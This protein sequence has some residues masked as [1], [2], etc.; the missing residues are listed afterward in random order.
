MP[1]SIIKLKDDCFVE[2]SSIC[3]APVTYC[4]T[5]EKFKEYLKEE[6]GN[7]RLALLLERLE[8]IDLGQ[9]CGQYDDLAGVLSY[10]RA[11]DNEK[12]IGLEKI[13]EKYTEKK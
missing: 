13:I 7:S 11:G 8:K 2:W 10:N 1:R 4:M 6:Y 5:K 12:K 3:D 9:A